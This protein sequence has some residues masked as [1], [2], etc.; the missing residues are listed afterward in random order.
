MA[1]GS[2]IEGGKNQAISYEVDGTAANGF[3]RLQHSDQPIPPGLTLDTADF[4]GDGGDL[5]T[6]ET[7][8]DLQTGNSN[9]TATGTGGTD[10]GNVWIVAS[11]VSRNRNGTDDDGSGETSTATETLSNEYT[12]PAFTANVESWLP[13]Y[14]NHFTVN[15]STASISLT[16]EATDP[17]PAIYYYITKLHYKWKVNAAPGQ[18][19]NWLEIFTPSD[20]TASI[21][22]TKTWTPSATDT[23]SS[24][25]EIDPAT[26][27]G[28]KSGEYSLAPL[29]IEVKRGGIGDNMDNVPTISTW[30]SQG[31]SIRDVVSIWDAHTSSTQVADLKGDW[32]QVRVNIGSLSEA[33]LPPNFIVWSI[34]GHPAPAPNTLETPRISWPGTFGAKTILATV[35]G[36]VYKVHIDV[37]NVGTLTQPGWAALMTLI[38]G[39]IDGPVGVLEAQGYA[40]TAITWSSAYAGKLSVQNALQHSYGIALCASDELINPA[41]ALA[42]GAA[43]ENN[44][45][46]RQGYRQWQVG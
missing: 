33:N 16:P 28:K 41:M 42:L 29:R 9:I 39:A 40:R 36:K 35:G 18:Q 23:E 32:L 1:E 44:N 6:T 34:N 43:H 13:A 11:D 10:Y 2:F 27:N 30:R 4:D 8:D 38:H 3:F 22:E 31:G 19:V 20:G 26:R 21:V 14:Q 25:Y 15:T 12:I 45:L 17:Y 24:V 5:T 7:F 46:S 37:P